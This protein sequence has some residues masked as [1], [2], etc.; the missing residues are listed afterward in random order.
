MTHRVSLSH[1]HCALVDDEDFTE[2]SKHTWTLAQHNGVNFYAIT[3]IKRKT[4]SMHRLLLN[5]QPGSLVE[6]KNDDGL[7]NRRENLKFGTR[8]SNALNAKVQSNSVSGV[9]G[10]TWDKQAGTWLVQAHVIGRKIFLGRCSNLET[11]IKARQTH[12]RAMQDVS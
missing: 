7:D 8:R 4:I 1:G 10:V 3:H 11:A 9:K 2:V 12:D 5:A 6:H